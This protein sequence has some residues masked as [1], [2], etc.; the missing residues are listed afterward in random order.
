M[1]APIKPGIP[2]SSCFR[3]EGVDKVYAALSAE[4]K[5]TISHRGKAMAGVREFLMNFKA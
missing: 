3:P 5:N 1:E 4:E 2:L